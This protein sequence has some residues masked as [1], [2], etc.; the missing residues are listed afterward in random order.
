MK[1]LQAIILAAGK[2]TRMKSK[3]PKVLHTICGRPLIQYVLDIIRSVGSLKTCVVLGHQNGK[4]REYLIE[5][6]IQSVIQEKLRGTADAIKCAAK[7][8][9]GYNGDVLI[10]SGDAPLLRKSTVKALIRKH[11]STGADCTFLTAVVQ[12]NHGYGRIIRGDNGRVFAIR[13]ENDATEYEKNI[14]EINVGTYCFKA[15]ALFKNLDDIKINKKKREFYLTDIVEIFNEEGL[16]IETV[17]IEDAKEGLGVNSR[18]DLAISESVIRRRIVDDLMLKGITIVD[19]STTFIYSDVKIDSDTIIHPFTVI[20]KNVHIGK[21][22]SIGPF[23]HLRP[24]TKIGSNVTVGNFAEVSRSSVGDR[25]LVKHFGF[26][27]DAH[28]GKDVNIGAGVVTANYDGKQKNKTRIANKAFIGSDSVLVAP[29]QVG[30]SAITG[31]GCVVTK[32]SIVPE[33][34]VIVGVPGKIKR[35]K[36]QK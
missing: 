22:C 29:V 33:R 36:K 23:A 10:L 15:A 12:D 32:G 35:K 27:G 8:F 4:V 34:G 25:S 28:V 5:E 21:A 31:A 14:V 16:K 11:K 17:E 30:K 24:G 26:L 3:T 13:E 6:K 9:R 18:I 1:D 20:E 19:P 7:Y 2:G